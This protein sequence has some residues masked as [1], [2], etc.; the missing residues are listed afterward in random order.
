MTLASCSLLHPSLWEEIPQPAYREGIKERPPPWW[1]QMTS[2]PGRDV[3]G[4][5][6]IAVPPAS[7]Q[8]HTASVTVFQ[9]LK[10][11]YSESLNI[12]CLINV[13][14]AEGLLVMMKSNLNVTVKADQILS[15]LLKADSDGKTCQSADFYHFVHQQSAVNIIMNN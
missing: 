4:A 14:E 6:R 15:L 5:V 8:I 12:V 11:R 10:Q 13:S 3:N 7:S 1:E 9:M 2:T